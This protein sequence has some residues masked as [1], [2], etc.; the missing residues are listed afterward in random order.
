MC[1]II[2]KIYSGHKLLLFIWKGQ[3]YS[4]EKMIINLTNFGQVLVIAILQRNRNPNCSKNAQFENKRQ[5]AI[6]I[7][8]FY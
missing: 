6:A 4:K 2:S 5:G 7:R 1:G 8:L 3:W